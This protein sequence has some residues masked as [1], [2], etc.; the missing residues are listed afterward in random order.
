[1]D[2]FILF[3][4]NSSIIGNADQANYAASNTYMESFAKYRTAQG[5]RTVLPDLGAM[6]KH[7]VLA[8]DESLR[9]RLLKGG[10]LSAVTP[11]VLFKLLKY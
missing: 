10:L 4:Y 8:E 3:T 2:F 11:A 5:E 1:M 6:L 9:E 7:G